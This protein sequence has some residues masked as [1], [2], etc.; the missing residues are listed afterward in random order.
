[1]LTQEQVLS[2]LKAG[3]ES[4]CLDGRD[5]ARLTDF[6]SETDFEKLGYSLKEGAQHTPKPWT[7]E[8]IKEQLAK[9]VA[10]GFEK[11]LDQRSI[12]ASMMY[13]VVKMWLWVLEDDLQHNEDY[14]EY[15][16]PFLKAVA[17]KYGLPNPIGEDA[18]TEDKYAMRE[19]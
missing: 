1:M 8:N 16:L 6:F 14:R 19:N 4:E 13:S 7:L 18:G 12:S 5:Y 17:T 2:A 9:D 10:F 11:A 3:R 15:G